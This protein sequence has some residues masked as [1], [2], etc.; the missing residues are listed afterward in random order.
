M[1]GIEIFLIIV[2]IGLVV[3]SFIITEKIEENTSGDE[4]DTKFAAVT[5]EIMRQQIDIAA[6]N[7]V[8]ETVEKTEVMLDKLSSEKIMAVSEYSDTV[9]KEINKNHDEV[10][11]LYSMLND[12]EKEIKNTVRDIENV[13]KTVN[14]IKKETLIQSEEAEVDESVDTENEIEEVTE[15]KEKNIFKREKK[16][17]REKKQK[18]LVEPR[19]NN[20]NDKILDMYNKGFSNVEIAKKLGIG[21]GEVRLVID[22]FKNRA[23]RNR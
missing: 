4:K 12:K 22:L 17:E 14:D 11:F 10:M 16:K 23:D 5:E 7:V 19:K 8:D 9:L 21:I 20:N 18:P 3:A 15:I 1:T 13:K 2:G 6:Q